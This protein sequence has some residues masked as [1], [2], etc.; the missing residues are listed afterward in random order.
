MLG[1]LQVTDRL[2]TVVIPHVADED[3][4]P[5][6]SR[7]LDRGQH[8]G[9]VKWGVADVEESDHRIRVGAPG[10]FEP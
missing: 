10:S 2:S 1:I 4:H 9:H 6:G 5:S 7:H 8:L 3:A